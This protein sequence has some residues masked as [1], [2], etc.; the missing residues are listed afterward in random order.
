[1]K[2]RFQFKVLE[3]SRNRCV[4]VVLNC[5]LLGPILTGSTKLFWLDFTIQLNNPYI[6]H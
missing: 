6:Y 4:L 3:I 1:M 5:L 2:E